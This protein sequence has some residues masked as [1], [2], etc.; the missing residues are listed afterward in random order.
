MQALA[1]IGGFTIDYT[2]Y[3]T[4]EVERGRDEPFEVVV[5]LD[6]AGRRALTVLEDVCGADLTEALNEPLLSIESQI[7]RNVTGEFEAMEVVGG[8]TYPGPPASSYLDLDLRSIAASRSGSHFE[9]SFGG[10]FEAQLSASL[11][12]DD[13]DPG[14][15]EEVQGEAF[16]AGTFN[17]TAEWDP[18]EDDDLVVGE[19]SLE[20]EQSNIWTE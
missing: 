13:K 10:T 20:Y 11:M 2:D 17:F 9:F 15:L 4:I 16:V 14:T 19:P 6:G 1:N 5:A 3:R 7:H 8:S 12:Q 18:S